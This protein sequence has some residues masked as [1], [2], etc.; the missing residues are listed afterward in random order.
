MNLFLQRIS[1]ETFRSFP[2]FPKC[3]ETHCDQSP[4]QSLLGSPS[5][6]L[7]KILLSLASCRLHIWIWSWNLCCALAY[8]GPGKFHSD[9]ASYRC[10]I[11]NSLSECL[12]A[13]HT[14][15][16]SRY[17]LGSTSSDPYKWYNENARPEHKNTGFGLQ[18]HGSS[19]VGC[20]A[21]YF[22]VSIA[23]MKTHCWHHLCA[24]AWFK[25]LTNVFCWKLKPFLC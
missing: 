22:L 18:T 25:T 1:G 8:R 13:S 7:F 11:T 3:P 15:M 24:F 5:K 19:L 2:N 20:M 12:L 4:D 6:T 21:L 17:S 23:G 14:A 16:S 9:E 10:L